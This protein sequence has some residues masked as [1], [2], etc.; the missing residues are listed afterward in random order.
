LSLRAC[1]QDTIDEDDSSRIS[2]DT[3]GYANV[4]RLIRS[5]FVGTAARRD[6]FGLNDAASVG[7]DESGITNILRFFTG[8]HRTIDHDDTVRVLNR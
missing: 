5:V 2:N 6:G 7:R 8:E 3:R 4:T 1:D